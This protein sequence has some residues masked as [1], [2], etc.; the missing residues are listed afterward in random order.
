MKFLRYIILTLFLST[1]LFSMSPWFQQIRQKI[2]S[3][4]IASTPTD[5]LM[6]DAL[7]QPPT[8]EIITLRHQVASLTWQNLQLQEQIATLTAFREKFPMQNFPQVVPAL[9]IAKKDNSSTF[10]RTF[11]INR[12]HKDG[13]TIGSPVLSGCTLVGRVAE[14]EKNWSRVV[15]LTDPSMR[16]GIEIIGIQDNQPYSYAKG[17]CIGKNTEFCELRNIEKSLVP[18]QPGELSIITTNF[19]EQ[20]PPGLVIGTIQS[21]YRAAGVQEK[22]PESGIFWD[23]PVKVLSIEQLNSVLVLLTEK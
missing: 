3:L 4:F 20:Y 19:R 8:P 2:I 14:T 5:Q 11:M 10:R 9:I 16:I 21:P 23:L 12:G 15:A 7:Q 17:L 1:I 22:T 6:V 13:I 18:W